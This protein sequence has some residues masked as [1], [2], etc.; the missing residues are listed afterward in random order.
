MPRRPSTRPVGEETDHYPRVVIRWDDPGDR[1]TRIIECRNQIQW[2][3]QHRIG[4]RNGA[5]VWRSKSFSRTR[6]ALQRILPG[7]ADEIASLL[8]ERFPDP[9]LSIT[10]RPHDHDTRTSR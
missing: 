6:A 10:E 8:P 9:A 5:P 7:K 1:A 2:C 4:T 3:V